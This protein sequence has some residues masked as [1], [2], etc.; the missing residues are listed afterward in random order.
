MLIKFLRSF[1]SVY[2]SHHLNAEPMDIP[3]ELAR[4]WIEA[5][6]ALPYEE[7]RPYQAYTYE[8]IV[9]M[10]ASEQHAFIQAH[11]LAIDGYKKSMKANE[12]EAALLA[13]LQL[14]Q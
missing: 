5:G 7:K 14:E 10:T 11:E 12:V 2:G 6:Y 8:E 3:D 1:G 4:N 9:R 13:F